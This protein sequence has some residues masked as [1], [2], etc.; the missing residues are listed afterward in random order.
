MAA[1]IRSHGVESF[2]GDHLPKPSA[3]LMAYTGH[4]DYSDNEPPT[5]GVVGEQDGIGAPS[6]MERLVI[7]LRKTGPRWSSSDT[8][9]S[10]TASAWVRHERGRVARPG[11]PVLGALDQI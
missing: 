2:G 6:V 8:T 10:V 4:S 1:A 11:H 9:V 7:A 5:F 3:V